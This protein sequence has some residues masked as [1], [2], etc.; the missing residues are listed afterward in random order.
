MSALPS[1]KTLTQKERN[2]L[3]AQIFR[4]EFDYVCRSLL[5]LGVKQLDM[6]DMAQE[7][8][9]T[10]HRKLE[11]FDNDR[12]VRPWLFAFA[13]RAAANYRRLKRHNNTSQEDAHHELA[14]HEATDEAAE[15]LQK[16]EL[17]L[18][19]LEHLSQDQRTIL[20]MH[21]LDGQTAPEIATALQIPLNTV[22]SR[23]RLARKNF[24]T[25]VTTHSEVRA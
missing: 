14:S 21:D 17:I 24:R 13:A 20:V 23:I 2:L 11:E 16:R 10:V 15:A 25:A 18:R 19:A 5:R 22:Y 7:V 4:D 1:Q 8:F 12:P 9:V 3:L 6:E